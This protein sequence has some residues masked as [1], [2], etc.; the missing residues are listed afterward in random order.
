QHAAFR[1]TSPFGD[2]VYLLELEAWLAEP[3]AAASEP[4]WIVF[5]QN[6]PASLVAAF[7]WAEANLP[8]GGC[9][10]NC[11]G[12]TAPP[13]LNVNDFI[14]FQARFAAGDCGANCDGSTAAPVLNVN[15]FI[16]FQALFA[17]GC[18]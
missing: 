1:L 11:D 12:S 17:A 9:D 16:C 18:R 8:G 14:C 3:G 10:A 15:D 13:I 6:T 7:E 4:F 5:D 2:G